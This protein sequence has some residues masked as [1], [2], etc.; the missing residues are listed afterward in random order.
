LRCRNSQ[1]TASSTLA[2]FLSGPVSFARLGTFGLVSL[3]KEA[4]MRE[5]E[6]AWLVGDDLVNQRHD[7]GEGGMRRC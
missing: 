7:Y 3:E 2:A 5:V 6:V 4:E 1:L